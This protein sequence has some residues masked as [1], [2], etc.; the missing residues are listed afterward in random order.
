MTLTG[1]ETFEIRDHRRVFGFKMLSNMTEREC[2]LV[3]NS[4]HH[5]SPTRRALYDWQYQQ[6]QRR[7]RPGKPPPFAA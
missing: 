3:A 7:N 6:R 4:L 1:R 5:R 2:L